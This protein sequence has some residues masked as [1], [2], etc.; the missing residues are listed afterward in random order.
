MVL[1]WAARWRGEGSIPQ[2]EHP[3]PP[4]GEVQHGVGHGEAAGWAP[5]LP[6]VLWLWRGW[7]RLECSWLLS[8]DSGSNPWKAM[9]MCWVCMGECCAGRFVMTFEQFLGTR[10]QV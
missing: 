6:E 10:V 1:C 3:S 9:Q 2:F 4:A 8:G 5:P 7:Q